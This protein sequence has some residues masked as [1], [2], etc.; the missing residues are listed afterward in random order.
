VRTSE[1]TST[2]DPHPFHAHSDLV[3]NLN[4]DPYPDPGCQ[5]AD[6]DLVLSLLHSFSDINFEYV[7]M[8]SFF[9]STWIDYMP[10]SS[11]NM[12]KF[13]ILCKN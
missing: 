11:I 3:Q 8:L 6:P 12:L 10:L 5:Y 1:N 7:D 9:Y 13:V 2:S 4:A